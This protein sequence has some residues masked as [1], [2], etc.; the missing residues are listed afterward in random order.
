MR[1]NNCEGIRR[2]LDELMLD[3]RASAAVSEHLNECSGCREFHQTQ[4]KLRQMVGSLGTVSAPADFEFRLRA[5]LASDANGRLPFGFAY[6][7]FARRG[8]AVASVV[9]LF[10]AG[11]LVMWNLMNQ[12]HANVAEQNSAPQQQTPRQTEAPGQSST[13]AGTQSNPQ[14]LRAAL[15][16][17][18]PQKSRNERSAQTGSRV[19]RQLSSVDFSG[20]GAEVISGGDPS[21][22]SVVF[23]IDASLQPVRVSLDDGHGNAKVISV[24]TISFGSQR[25]FASGNQSTQKGNW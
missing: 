22:T 11:A 2:E 6:W 9:V 10:A 20:T 19:R 12:P 18:N 25:T 14:E 7:P 1:K 17:S 15:P 13:P 23:P 24:P 21:D 16:E 4:T 8:L 5:R 3:E